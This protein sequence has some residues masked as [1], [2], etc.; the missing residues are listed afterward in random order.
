MIPPVFRMKR[1]VWPVAYACLLAGAVSI[2]AAQ[3]ASGLETVRRI[4]AVRALRPEN[5]A[6]LTETAL[7][8]SLG[9]TQFSIERGQP[10]SGRIEIAFTD[11]QGAPLPLNGWISYDTDDGKDKGC[12]VIYYGSG[13]AAV[14]EGRATIVLHG[15]ERRAIVHT[16]GLPG[17][18]LAKQDRFRRKDT[19]AVISLPEGETHAREMLPLEPAGSIRWRLA[20]EHGSPETQRVKYWL[21]TPMYSTW[22]EIEPP[23]S[24]FLLRPARFGEPYRLV[25]QKGSRFADSSPSP[26]SAGSPAADL[27]I[28]FQ[29]G[30]TITGSLLNADGRPL[31]GERLRLGYQILEPQP[32]MLESVAATV[33]DADGKFSFESINLGMPNRYWL[34]FDP[35]DEVG[36][37]RRA[38]PMHR[39]AVDAR[40][41]LPVEIRLP[42]TH[43]AHGRLLDAKTARPVVGVRVWALMHERFSATGRPN[44]LPVFKVPAVAPTDESGLFRFNNLPAGVYDFSLSEGRVAQHGSEVGAPDNPV[45]GQTDIDL[46][47]VP[48]IGENAPPVFWVRD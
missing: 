9:R 19:K 22:S 21:Y 35:S 36:A 10:E 15:R 24:R 3:D 25:I 28:A 13:I 31:A 45:A 12:L 26:L 18:A 23:Y 1:C 5:E 16:E 40:T 29:P 43:E 8:A 20:D 46:L 32:T 14:A 6:A 2:V 42:E 39:I 33:T 30:K 37:V 4:E 48:Q 7:L 38:L 44:W 34:V 11:E 47:R 41:P 27:V 17:Y